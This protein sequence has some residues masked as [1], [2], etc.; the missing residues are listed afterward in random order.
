MR[1]PNSQC[2][3]H[4]HLN[5]LLLWNVAALLDLKARWGVVGE[6]CTFALLQRGD[7]VHTELIP[8]R[9]IIFRCDFEPHHCPLP[10]LS[11]TISTGQLEWS[12]FCMS[13][14]DWQVPRDQAVP[15]H[16]F[17]LEWLQPQLVFGDSHGCSMLWRCPASTVCKLHHDYQA[18]CHFALLQN[19]LLQQCP[20]TVL[21]VLYHT[22]RG[23][24]K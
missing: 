5:I 10:L 18:T 1:D 24:L 11:C 7:P 21:C 13:C 2:H 9:G 23:M 15:C 4:G 20:A 17:L 16:V 19:A 6:M 3:H 22:C 14:R 12:H 8:I